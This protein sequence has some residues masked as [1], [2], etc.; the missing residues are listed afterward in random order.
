MQKQQERHQPDA[1]G[2]NLPGDA[3][4]RD[5]IGHH[6]TVAEHRAEIER[7]ARRSCGR[8][9]PA[10]RQNQRDDDKGAGSAG[11]R[12][13]KGPAPVEQVTHHARDQNGQPGAQRENRRVICRAAFL[14]LARGKL[15]G[16]RLHAR[17]ERAR[18]TDPG[19]HPEQGT[20]PKPVRQKTEP[21][22]ADHAQRRAGQ[23]DTF[24]IDAVGIRRQHRHGDDVACK[25]CAT[26]PA[27]LRIRQLPVTDDLA[28][29]R[30][31]RHEAQQRH[32]QRGAEAGD[33]KNRGFQTTDT[34]I[35]PTA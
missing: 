27:R 20:A 30:G 26:E 1:V 4:R 16:H 22:I 14:G 9:R 12:D 21:E 11:R 34:T 19:Q 17:H 2:E 13:R 33:K 23:V 32:D 29:N 3:E 5:D 18:Q 28:E 7:H 35:L 25:Q 24:R 8:V 10:R 6:G 31:R 15:I